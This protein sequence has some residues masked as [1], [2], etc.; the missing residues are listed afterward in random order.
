MASSTCSAAMRSTSGSAASMVAHQ[1]HRAE[2]APAGR[3]R[4]G[5]RQALQ[6]ALDRL[7][8]GFAEGRV[9]GDQDRLR[10]HVMLGLGQKVGGDPVRI[11]AAVGDHQHFR[12]PGD[13]VDADRA[14][15]LAL[16]GGD[17][18]IAGADDLGDRPDRLGAI[19]KGGDRLRAADAVDLRNA[20]DIGRHQHQR[21]DDAARRRHHHDDALDAGH[22]GRHGVHQH[23]AR[24]ARRAARHIEPDRLDRRPAR[25]EFDAGGIGI[26]VVL[27]L[28]PLVMGSGCGRGRI[29]APRPSAD[30]RPCRP[31]R[32]RPSTRRCRACSGRPGRISACSRSAPRRPR[33]APAR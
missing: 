3:R 27:R 28:L 5:A 4:L 11:V 1:D 25:A 17:I 15:H 32:C 8:D 9:V 31:A 21:I 13:H 24:I 7:F 12:R 10:R 6:L 2:I 33:R 26:A 18:G 14:E 30:R 16:G 20:G 23:R 22:P 19:G 29:S